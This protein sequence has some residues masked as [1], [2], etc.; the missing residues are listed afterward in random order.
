MVGCTTLLLLWMVA[1]SYAPVGHGNSET[2][3][4]TTADVYSCVHSY[5][6]LMLLD[7]PYGPKTSPFLVGEPPCLFPRIGLGEK[8]DRKPYSW[9]TH[10][11]NPHWM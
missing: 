6:F 11:F 4:Y 3:Y 8:I 9:A 7:I 5:P 1:K 10:S 2:L